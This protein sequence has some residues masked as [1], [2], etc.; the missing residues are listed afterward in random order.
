MPY[1]PNHVARGP[2]ETKLQPRYQFC[3]CAGTHGIMPEV[4]E[5]F[6]RSDIG[7]RG[8]ITSSQS[9]LSTSLSEISICVTRK[10]AT[11]RNGCNVHKFHL[12]FKFVLS[13]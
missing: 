9:V 7:S 4:G 2:A 11:C 10:G 5:A 6:R 13:C 12:I 8:L 3:D 1:P